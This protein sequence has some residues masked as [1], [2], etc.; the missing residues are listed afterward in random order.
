MSLKF[1]YKE[2]QQLKKVGLKKFSPTFTTKRLRPMN[3]FIRFILI[4]F[5]FL[6]LPFIGDSIIE[7]K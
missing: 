7:S 3:Y 1:Y 4:V 2:V 6:A 5:E